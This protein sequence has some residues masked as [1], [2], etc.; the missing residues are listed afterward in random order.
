LES[1]KGISELKANYDH[2]TLDP[3]EEAAVIAAA[4]HKAKSA[5]DA[6]LKE[7]AYLT[8]LNQPKQYHRFDM[9]SLERFVLSKHT[10]Y[11]VDDN[12]REIFETLCMYFS[13]D[14]AFELQGEDFSFKK[15][16]MLYGPVGCGKTSLMK[17]FAINSFRPFAVSSCRS[18]ADD[19]A[20]EGAT[21]LYKY[22][23]LQPVFP[24][25][26]FGIPS[27]GRCFDDLGTEDNKTNF[28]N[29]V[30]VMQDVLYK[31]YDNNLIGNFHMT[32][33][34]IGDEIEAAYGQRIRSRM[35]EMFN[36]LSFSNSS[37][38]RRR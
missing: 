38:D 2:I 35:R 37:P 25:L 24:D 33:N 13:N 11:V 12:N 32:T 21:S 8:K 31:I 7:I 4:I 30:N 18:I 15:G 14:Q 6:R 17:M 27:I 36:V 34:I 3:E 16:I 28:G 22:S 19:Y 26:N 10:G 29:K 5:K 9:E 1:Y 23:D 20:I